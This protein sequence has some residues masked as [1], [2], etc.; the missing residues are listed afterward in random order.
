MMMS[1]RSLNPVKILKEQ[2]HMNRKQRR[3]SAKL[4]RSR[5][6]LPARS[7]SKAATIPDD[8]KADIAQ[9]VR[10]IEFSGADGGT[11][12]FRAALGMDFLRRLGIPCG[13]ALGGMVYRAGPDPRRDVVS[14][15]GWGNLGQIIPGKGWLG[16][17]W[18]QSGT[19]VIDFS[20]GDWRS[21]ATPDMLLDLGPMGDLVPMDDLGPIQWTVEPPNFFWVPEATVAPIVGQYTPEIGRAYYTGW[22]GP[23]P[24]VADNLRE[25]TRALDWQLIVRHFDRT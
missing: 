18:V 14:Y 8:L 22:R 2:N 1:C 17:Y 19:D 7:Q 12:F 9:S 20:T 6:R 13:I 15:C 24:P 21:E 5:P 16:H 11:C 23:T 25:L 3:A 4:D 10:N